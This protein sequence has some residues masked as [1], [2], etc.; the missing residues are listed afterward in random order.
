MGEPTT[1]WCMIYYMW[2][3]YF[4]IIPFIF[5]LHFKSHIWRDDAVVISQQD[6]EQERKLTGCNAMCCRACH[7]ERKFSGPGGWRTKGDVKETTGAQYYAET[8]G[9]LSRKAHSSSLRQME[10]GKRQNRRE[11]YR[12]AMPGDPGVRPLAMLPSHRG[13]PHQS[14]ISLHLFLQS[15]QSS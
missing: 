14:E 5:F 6:S 10:T 12:Q 2:D 9:G 1:L 15:G 11:L 7:N 13:K 3:I 4:F 8:V